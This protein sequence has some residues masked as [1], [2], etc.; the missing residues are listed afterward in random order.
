[1]T[2]TTT[3]NQTERNL[4][5]QD[6]KL[7]TY[8]NSL[9]FNSNYY[10]V[11]LCR[12]LGVCLPVTQ[13]R[14]WE[15]SPD[16]HTLLTVLNTILKRSKCFICLL[17][18][19]IMSIIAIATTAAVVG[20]AHHQ[21]V[22]TTAFVQKWHKNATSVWGTKIH[23]D[24]EINIRLVDLEN[25]VLL[26]GEEVQNLKFQIQLK[27]DWNITTFY[28]TLPPPPTPPPPPPRSHDP[29]GI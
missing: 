15:L 11:I 2:G 3:I 24:E 18:A 17:I 8:L 16:V 4:I 12:H 6:C 19:T 22:H 14:P 20:I 9:L 25:A 23:I 29:P 10:Y 1:M 7:H 27:C 5:C 13:N 21:M 28:V 26:L